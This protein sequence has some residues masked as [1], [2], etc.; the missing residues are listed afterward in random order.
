MWGLH[1]LTLNERK[2]LRFIPTYVGFTAC[3]GAPDWTADGSSPRMWG[4]PTAFTQN[5]M[6]MR[7]IPTYVGFTA[8]E[9]CGNRCTSVHPHACGVYGTARTASA[10]PTG[11]S[12]R[13]WGLHLVSVGHVRP[14]RFI[15]TYVGFTLPRRCQPRSPAVHPHVCGVY[16]TKF[17]R[18]VII[19][20]FIPTY[21]GFTHILIV[22]S[23]LIAVHPHVCGV[24]D[25]SSTNSPYASGSSPRMWGLHSPRC[26][27]PGSL[28]FIPTYVGFTRSW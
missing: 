6:R 5:S 12:P 17:V 3:A 9:R 2:R 1:E 18:N 26:P 23:S 16:E 27:A 14:F 7:F 13:M 22:S 25:N 24:Y 20:W 19:S 28:R 4:L 21:V 10:D 8:C 15:P 11:S